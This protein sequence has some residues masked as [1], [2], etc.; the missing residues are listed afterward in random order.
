MSLVEAEPI[1]VLIMTDN[2]LKDEKIIAVAKNDPFY[3]CYKDISEVPAHIM[4]EIKHFF[5]VY[6]TLENKATSV[7]VFKN[8]EAAIEIINTCLEN[9]RHQIE[10]RIIAE[11]KARGY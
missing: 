2:G 11:R 7:D 3:N 10:P 9:Y 4:D 5:T 6:K 8:R 1:G